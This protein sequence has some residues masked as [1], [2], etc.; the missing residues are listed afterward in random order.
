MQQEEREELMSEIT[1]ISTEWEEA[2]KHN[3]RLLQKLKDKE[4]SNAHLMK[5]RI[6]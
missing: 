4:G 5:E 3:A 6:R 2:Q 1:S